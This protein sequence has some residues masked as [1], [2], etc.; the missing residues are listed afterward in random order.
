M[1]RIAWR[2]AVRT[3]GS[4][5]RAVS[6]AR[7][8]SGSP[9]SSA[10][11]CTRRPVSMKPQVDALTNSDSVAPRWRA[12]SPAASL[13]AISLSAV[14]LS[15]IRS[16]AS[17]RHIRITPS[18]EARSYSCRNA[19]MPPRPAARCRTACTSARARRKTS[20]ESAAESS[21]RASSS[22]THCVSSASQ[23]ALIARPAAELKLSEAGH[24]AA[25]G[26][27]HT[28]PGTGAQ[29][30]KIVQNRVCAGSKAW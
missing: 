6:R 1:M 5:S 30:L 13:S 20:A 11:G 21:A 29:L 19:S 18:R 25:I 8:V 2:S 26:C 3:S 12:Q 17:A 14:S 4:P 15:G 9:S 7:K 10:A 16:S 27:G 23:E 22:V 24:G 28:L